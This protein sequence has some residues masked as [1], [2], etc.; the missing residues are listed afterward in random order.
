MYENSTETKTWSEGPFQDDAK[1]LA[2]MGN[3]KD[4]LMMIPLL[5]TIIT[6]TKTHSSSQRRDDTISVL[7]EHLSPPATTD[8]ANSWWLWE[9]N[10]VTVEINMVPGDHALGIIRLQYIF[11]LH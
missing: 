11:I 2:A 1:S 4:N 10:P 9:L 6:T 5:I 7:P 8:F 3:I